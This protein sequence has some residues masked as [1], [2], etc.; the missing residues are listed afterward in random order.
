M[1]EPSKAEIE[2][3]GLLKF[4][5]LIY[6]PKGLSVDKAILG[7]YAKQ[8][9]NANEA[10]ALAYISLMNQTMSKFYRFNEN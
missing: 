3:A 5:D 10:I 6:E 2:N 1:N 7:F 4:L 8:G 9:I